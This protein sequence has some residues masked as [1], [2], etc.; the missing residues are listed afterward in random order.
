MELSICP[1]ALRRALP[2]LWIGV[3]LALG[4]CAG[5][6]VIYLSSPLPSEVVAVPAPPPGSTSAAPRPRPAP[7]GSE[8]PGR[9]GTTAAA[10]AA[11][12]HADPVRAAPARTAAAR[13]AFFPAAV[14][15]E[16]ATAAPAVE[17]PPSSSVFTKGSAAY[18]IPRTM[19]EAETSPVD[20]WID[21]SAAPAE[22]G[23]QLEQMLRD[24]AARAAARAGADVKVKFKQFGETQVVT[25]VV[26]IGKKM[27]AELIGVDFDIEPK[28]RQEETVREGY[29]LRWSWQVRP[30]K[31]SEQGLLLELRV[32]ADP[33]DGGLPVES[34]RETVPV[35][36]RPQTL[37]E[38]FKGIDGWIQSLLGVSVAGAL[39]IL[40]KWI[41]AKRARMRAYLRSLWARL[42]RR[43]QGPIE[44]QR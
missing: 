44:L 5:D 14:A 3:A 6:G 9:A 4:G 40:G 28:G 13:A 27:Y 17:R 33:G 26:E 19:V 34:I 16:A 43:P 15:A 39:G 41:W 36:A 31:A 1:A 12:A 18:Q 8:V 20:L 11:P 22:L 42:R 10:A 21:T 7:P 38:V 37:L 23:R 29:P 2:A 35:K 30:K 24:N 25:K 32:L